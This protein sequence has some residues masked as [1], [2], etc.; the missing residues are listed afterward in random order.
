MSVA[1]D[2]TQDSTINSVLSHDFASDLI[3]TEFSVKHDETISYGGG[4][5]RLGS[6]ISARKEK[7]NQNQF[8]KTAFPEYSLCLSC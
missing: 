5:R 1:S 4:V 7:K 6:K 3:L 2:I 8:L